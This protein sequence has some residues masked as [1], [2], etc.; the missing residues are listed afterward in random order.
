MSRSVPAPAAGIGW[1]CAGKSLIGTHHTSMT[2]THTNTNSHILCY[3]N[4]FLILWLFF[5]IYPSFLHT[6]HG[7]RLA[8]SSL[9][10]LFSYLW[11]LPGPPPPPHSLLW[12]GEAQRTSSNPTAQRPDLHN[13]HVVAGNRRRGSDTLGADGTSNR[14]GSNPD[15][16][17]LF[18]TMTFTKLAKKRPGHV[19]GTVS[20]GADVSKA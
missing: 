16:S 3:S 15:R 17:D 1:G 11:H 10:P 13:Q 8:P 5:L 19:K 4:T 14:C 9:K 12:R 6:S 7:G 20:F 18:S 2:H